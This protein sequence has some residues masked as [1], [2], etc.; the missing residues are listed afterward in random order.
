MIAFHE[1]TGITFDR[2]GFGDLLVAFR[3]FDACAAQL[4]ASGKVSKRD[5]L[6]LL[7]D[8]RS[9]VEKTNKLLSE[10]MIPVRMEAAVSP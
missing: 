8:L 7:S 10:Q 2:A 9:A 6:V 3:W 1:V 5:A 4:V